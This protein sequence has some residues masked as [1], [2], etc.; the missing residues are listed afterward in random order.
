V[1]KTTPRYPDN[2]YIKEREAL[3]NV[4][5]DFLGF[6]FRPRRV[7]RPRDKILFCGYT[8]AVSPSAM[9]A[10]R[11]TIRDLNLRRQTQLSLQ[12]IARQLNPLIR[13]WL[14]YYGRYTRS[15]LDPLLRYVNQ[16]LVAWAARKFK[17]FN[18]SKLQAGRF[19]ERVAQAERALFVHWEL[20]MTGMSA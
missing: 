5:F 15:A 17:R 20:G 11:Q 3:Q 8:P 16:T 14:Q 2:I 19:L 6:C 13:G 1:R 10:I 7:Q 9:K 18:R 4:K 12:E